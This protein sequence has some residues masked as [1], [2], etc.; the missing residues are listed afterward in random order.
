[1][2][3]TYNSLLVLLNTLYLTLLITCIVYATYIV[4]HLNLILVLASFHS[5]YY[6]IT[7]M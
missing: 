6:D 7:F 2:F 3:L 4:L 1:M 5:I